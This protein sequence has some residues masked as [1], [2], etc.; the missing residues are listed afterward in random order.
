MRS[1]QNVNRAVCGARMD[2]FGV[3]CIS[4]K[5]GGA[6]LAA[7]SEGNQILA[8]AC[9]DAGYT[10]RRE[11]IIPELATSACSSLQLDV[12]MFGVAGA[13]RLLIDFT[14]RSSVAARYRFGARTDATAS[15][16]EEK[17]MR[18]PASGGV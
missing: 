14:L 17:R 9:R 7:H 11:Q 2:A 3:H 13:D 16:E 1:G 6:V 10:A 15:A 18:H 8:E 12:D 5:I 4:C